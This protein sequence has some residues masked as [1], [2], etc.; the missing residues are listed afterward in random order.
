M[1]KNSAADVSSL[2][3]TMELLLRLEVQQVKGQ[4]NQT[5]MIL[6]LDSLGFRPVEIAVALGTTTGTVNPIL[7]KRRA[8]KPATRSK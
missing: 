5:D 7:S 3:R 1:A 4:R 6:L 8:K 2:E